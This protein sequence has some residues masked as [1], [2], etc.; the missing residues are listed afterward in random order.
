MDYEPCIQAA[1]AVIKSSE[2]PNYTIITKE[3][4]LTLSTL[5]W[6]AQGKTTS[7]E[8]FQSQVHQ[9]LTNAQERILIK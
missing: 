6:R 5:I 9:C 3:Y 1:L 7:R 4:K 2:K 8:E